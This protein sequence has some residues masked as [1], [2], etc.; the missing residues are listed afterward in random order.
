MSP[1]V[2]APDSGNLLLGKGK[3]YFNRKS[4]TGT[5]AGY[6]HLGN[7]E[8]FELTTNDDVLE[9]YSSM[10][11]AAPLYK[12]VTRRRTVTLN[13]TLNE[14]DPENVALVL[15]GSV[16]SSSQVATPVVDETVSTNTLVG[17]TYRFSKLGPHTAITAKKSPAT[18]LVAGTDYVIDDT[19]LGLIRILSNATL[20]DGSTLLVSYT[21]TAYTAPA[22][23]IRTIEAGTLTI[24]EG[25]VLF[26]PDPTLG[27]KQM[28]E[29]WSVS[30]RPDGAIG[31]ISDDYADGGLVM[32]VQDDSVNHPT[33]P[34]YRVTFLA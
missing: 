11:A 25:A 27:P 34:L 3:V 4:V 13:L 29:V 28:V 19:N 14:F 5:F 16:I 12:Q 10:S 2:A 22:T 18:A 31:L 33:S 7:V 24:I 20:T 21:P 1:L 23:G 8:K 9:K 26:V 32:A 6:R 15:M 17:R 30:S